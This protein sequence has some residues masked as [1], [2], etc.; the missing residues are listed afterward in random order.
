VLVPR[1][2]Q[3]VGLWRHALGHLRVPVGRRANPRMDRT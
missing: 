3:A 2:V 1:V